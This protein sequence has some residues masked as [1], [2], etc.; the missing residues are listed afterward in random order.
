M[1][2][3]TAS[4]VVAADR[5]LHDPP[6]W[7][8]PALRRNRERRAAQTRP[9]V[10]PLDV[11][12]HVAD[13]LRERDQWVLRVVLGPEEAVF[14][15]IPE[16]D[17]DRTAWARRLRC[18]APHDGQR[19]GNARRVVGGAVADRVGGFFG[20]ARAAEVV[21]VRADEHVLM[22]EVGP[23]DH[24]D[25]VRAGGEILGEGRVA[26]AGRVGPHGDGLQLVDQVLARDR[27][28]RRRV[29]P[30][31]RVVAR[32]LDDVDEGAARQDGREQHR[33]GEREPPPSA[34]GLS[35]GPP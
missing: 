27:R 16:R 30:P 23:G 31:E 12:V 8:S 11:E 5:R 7:G 1:L 25:D 20:V 22:G 10:G 2:S 28:T 4:S 26:G 32:E 3:C 19:R 9:E 34:S 24:P 15:A 21:V 33:G 14:L 13:R 17:D 29:G 6:Q 18:D 35:H